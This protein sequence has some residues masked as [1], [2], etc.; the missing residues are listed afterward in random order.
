MILFVAVV[1]K[2]QRKYST[3]SKEYKFIELKQFKQDS[4]K[5]KICDF[6]V[7]FSLSISPYKIYIHVT[8]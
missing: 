1:S 3:R 4:I 7:P 8:M 5:K 2:G 6:Q